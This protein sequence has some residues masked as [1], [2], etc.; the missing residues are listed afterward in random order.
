[1]GG[2]I[3]SWWIKRPQRLQSEIEI[4]ENKFPQFLS[5]ETHD[6]LPEAFQ[7]EL[8][9]ANYQV[10]PINKALIRK[11]IHTELGEYPETLFKK[12]EKFTADLIKG[13]FWGE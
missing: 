11:I 8:D 12:F 6:L 5:L 1:M 10:S 7:K 4:M 9:K 2:N 13:K 3:M